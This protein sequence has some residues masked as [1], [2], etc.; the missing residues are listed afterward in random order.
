MCNTLQFIEKVTGR[1]GLT[2]DGL[3]PF[4]QKISEFSIRLPELSN[5][6]FCLVDT[7]GL[8][9]PTDDLEPFR[10]ISAWLLR[11]YVSLKYSQ[12]PP[13]FHPGAEEIGV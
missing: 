3:Q 13:N 2:G 5:S 12:I 9:S 4:T 7:P 6:E 8:D 1:T 11:L 10:K